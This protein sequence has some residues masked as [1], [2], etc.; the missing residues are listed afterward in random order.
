[1]KHNL[2][3][4]EWLRNIFSNPAL[5][6]KITYRRTFSRLLIHSY[7]RRTDLLHN[8]SL[9]VFLT[10]NKFV[11]CGFADNEILKY[12]GSYN[13]NLFRWIPVDF[14]F[15]FR[16]KMQLHWT[17]ARWHFLYKVCLPSV[18]HA[19]EIKTAW[20]KKQL[21][22]IGMDSYQLVLLISCPQWNKKNT[23]G[24]YFFTNFIVKKSQIDILDKKDGSR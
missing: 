12:I 17:M 11:P 15:R 8:L 1:M 3:K 4:C 24:I 16:D 5:H 19:D 21:S 7:C 20:I 23:D 2:S 6:K 13:V 14:L 10:I 22:N 9:H 18:N